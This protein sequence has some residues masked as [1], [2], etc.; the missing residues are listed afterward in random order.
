MDYKDLIV[1]V[2]IVGAA[3]HEYVELKEN[4][5]APNPRAPHHERSVSNYQ[6]S[7]TAGSSMT[8]AGF[9]LPAGM[10]LGPN[11]F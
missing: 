2:I 4:G 9:T 11:K 6:S 5:I 1:G 10:K 8:V 7:M 3:G